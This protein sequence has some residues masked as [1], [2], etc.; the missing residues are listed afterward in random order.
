M[1]ILEIDLKNPI[2]P[3]EINSIEEKLKVI[4][5]CDFLIIDTG[6]HD[7]ESIEVIK[8]FRTQMD[9]LGPY[10]NLFKKIAL[11]RPSQYQ[12]VSTNPEVYYFF[13]SKEE[14]RAWF[15]R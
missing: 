15:S 3:E 10:L 5:G 8:Y 13:D 7:F 1:N 6:E 12:N 14:A 9:N 4:K 2:T 11:I